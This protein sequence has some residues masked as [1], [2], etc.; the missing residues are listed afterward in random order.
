MATLP[1][2]TPQWWD[3]DFDDQGTPIRADVR[4]AAHKLW[5]DACRRVRSVLGDKSDAAELL[6]ATVLYISHHLDRISAPLFA[7]NVP[8]LVSLNFCQKLRHRAT[9]L[10]RIK[11][12]GGS[13]D[14]EEYAT[15]PDW[16]DEVNRRIDFQKLKP[17]LSDQSYTMA[18][19]REM[20]HEWKEV[21]AKIGI[22]PSTAR[23]SF[24]QE[25]H[26][27]LSKR[28]GEQAWRKMTWEQSKSSS[29]R[30]DLP[31]DLEPGEAELLEA[32]V[33]WV[34]A[35]HPNPERKG[36]PGKSVLTALVLT[37]KKFEDEYT[38][39]HIGRCAACLDELKQ[40][41]REVS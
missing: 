24:W 3:R 19:M 1:E 13:A 33:R 25:T 20:G 27:A 9:K 41:K 17:Y 4:Q 7:E 37:K 32:Y 10:G 38:L 28:K 11:C 40:I 16:D 36:C 29:G 34:R 26:R 8:S 30:T 5:P 23:S 15:V 14:I 31:S 18:L 12:V 22:D 39:M 2:N 21:G 35:E 6:E